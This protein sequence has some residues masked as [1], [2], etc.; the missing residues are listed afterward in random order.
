MRA[1]NRPIWAI[2]GLN[3]FGQRVVAE[4]SDVG[5]VAIPLPEIQ[6]VADHEAIRNFEADIPDRL[7]HAYFGADVSAPLAS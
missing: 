1:T 4:H 2:R 3:A 7:E 5:E 6:A